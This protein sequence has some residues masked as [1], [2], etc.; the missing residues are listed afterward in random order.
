MALEKIFFVMPPQIQ[1]PSYGGVAGSSCASEFSFH[2]FELTNET[3]IATDSTEEHRL[4]GLNMSEP[5]EEQSSVRCHAASSKRHSKKR[6]RE[7]GS[8][9]HNV[10]SK[11]H[12]EEAHRSFQVK[13]EKINNNFSRPSGEPTDDLRM[14]EADINDL[15]YE[16]LAGR[17]NKVE[18]YLEKIVQHI[19]RHPTDSPPKRRRIEMTSETQVRPRPT[20]AAGCAGSQ[21]M[22]GLP[23]WR[24]KILVIMKSMTL[25]MKR[26]TTCSIF[27]I[28]HQI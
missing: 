23:L 15:R 4:L 11:Q 16:A 2:G 25:I 3:C 14:S 20:P 26:R 5:E 19:S 27:L 7:V 6:P 18:S 10:I 24:M 9:K 22:T 21:M 1:F 13:L 12:N 17:I 28:Q 8:M